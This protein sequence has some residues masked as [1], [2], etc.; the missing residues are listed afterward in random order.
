MAPPSIVRDP[1]FRRRVHAAGKDSW[2]KE[3][4]Q[5]TPMLRSDTAQNSPSDHARVSLSRGRFRAKKLILTERL[6]RI[7]FQTE[8][9]VHKNVALRQRRSAW[10]EDFVR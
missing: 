7:S 9:H 3:P 2:T 6:R 4:L 8:A 5:V 10:N 1:H